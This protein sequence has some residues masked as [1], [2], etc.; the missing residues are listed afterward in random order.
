MY[1]LLLVV[2]LI[3]CLNGVHNIIQKRERFLSTVHPLASPIKDV[4]FYDTRRCSGGNKTCDK[5]AQTYTFL[6]YKQGPTETQTFCPPTYMYNGSCT[7][8]YPNNIQM[9]EKL[10]GTRPPNFQNAPAPDPISTYLPKTPFTSN[11]SLQ[12]TLDK[13]NVSRCIVGHN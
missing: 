13:H 4:A 8:T 5:P 2:L 6:P 10:Y 9:F 11:E 1:A 7:P 3:F 12:C